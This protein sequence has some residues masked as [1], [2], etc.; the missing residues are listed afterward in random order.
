MS[1]EEIFTCDRCR[2]R[3]NSKWDV[4]RVELQIKPADGCG[5]PTRDLCV[6]CLEKVKQLIMEELVK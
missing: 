1:R 2:T 5:T 3:S 4:R 6:P